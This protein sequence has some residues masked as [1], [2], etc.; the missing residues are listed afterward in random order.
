MSGRLESAESG[1]GGGWTPRAGVAVHTVSTSAARET[2][3]ASGHRMSAAYPRER[4]AVK[5]FLAAPGSGAFVCADRVRRVNLLRM[6]P[7]PRTA[8]V[9]SGGGARGAYQVGVLHGLA[10]L[11]ILPPGPSPF[12]IVVG[13]S[14]GAIN[15]TALAAY[16]DAFHEGVSRLERVWREIRPSDVFRTDVASLGRIGVRWAWDLS[17]GG[18]TG[19][20]RARS[21]LDTSPPPALLA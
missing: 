7:P 14:A 11:G 2:F 19:R 10:E 17:V 9:L 6:S 1:R 13:S 5:Q 18:A 15:A 4:A 20:V 16:A 8:L 12:D 21:L 3:A